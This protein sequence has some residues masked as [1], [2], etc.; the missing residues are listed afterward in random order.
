MLDLKIVGGQIA[1]GTG[2]P[3]L[4]SKGMAP[5]SETT[6]RSPLFQKRSA[7]PGKQVRTAEN[8]SFEMATPA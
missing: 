1:D 2:R 4:Q 5:T 3:L 6:Q 7:L 8:C